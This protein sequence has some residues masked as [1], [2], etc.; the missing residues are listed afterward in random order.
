MFDVFSLHRQN[1]FLRV[2]EA[3]AGEKAFILKRSRADGVLLWKSWLMALGWF[4]GKGMVGCW[5]SVYTKTYNMAER[6]LLR[7]SVYSFC[8]GRAVSRQDGVLS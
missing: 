7:S 1:R 5:N 6:M 3:K 4:P 2:W 8:S